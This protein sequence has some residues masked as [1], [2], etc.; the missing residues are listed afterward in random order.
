MVNMVVTVMLALS[1]C[2]SIFRQLLIKYV[3]MLVT[4]SSGY[5]D[6]V[7]NLSIAAIKTIVSKERISVMPYT[8]IRVGMEVMPNRTVVK[9]MGPLQ[10]GV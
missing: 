7:G 4:I 1:I 3:E 8:V 9:E 2:K 10:E 5:P 6:W